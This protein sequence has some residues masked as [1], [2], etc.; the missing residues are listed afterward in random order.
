[1]LVC[2]SSVPLNNQNAE[3]FLSVLDLG[4]PLYS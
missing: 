4:S 1:M 2:F 3:R